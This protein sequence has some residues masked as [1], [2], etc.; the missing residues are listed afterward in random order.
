ML[1]DG[2]YAAAPGTTHVPPPRDDM[3][4]IYDVRQHDI[5]TSGPSINFIYDMER[6]RYFVRDDWRLA[7]GHDADGNVLEGSFD[8]LHEAHHSGCDL[9]I[10]LR[11]L[12]AGDAHDIITPV[13]SSW[14]HTAHGTLEA[15]T[16]PLMRVAASRP[17]QYASGAWDVAWVFAAP[18]RPIPP[19]I[20]RRNG[21]VCLPLVRAVTGYRSQPVV[22][23]RFGDSS[24]VRRL[25]LFNT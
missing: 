9:K 7:L 24:T 8:A 14:I 3:P 21:A 13:G 11:D 23:S 17:L 18:A 15:L 6:F 16:H 10:A 12:A 2:A 5:G 1:D 4:K 25:C 19:P 22:D 20:L